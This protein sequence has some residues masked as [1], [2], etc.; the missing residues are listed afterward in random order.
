MVTQEDFVT[1]ARHLCLISNRMKKYWRLYVYMYTCIH[2]DKPMFYYSYKYLLN[3][4][5]IKS[6]TAYNHCNQT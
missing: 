5:C 3:I 4:S 2:V 1:M 6:A